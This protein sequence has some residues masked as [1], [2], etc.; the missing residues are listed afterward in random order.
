LVDSIAFARAQETVS[1]QRRVTSSCV[2]IGFPVNFEM[3][4]FKKIT[5]N[6][7]KKVT[8]HPL[9]YGEFA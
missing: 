4:Q 3:V 9:I 6:H 1:P 8:L 5:K 2:P 7:P